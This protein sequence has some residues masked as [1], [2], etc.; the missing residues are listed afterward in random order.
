MRTLQENPK[1]MGTSVD[2]RCR[3]ATTLK[4]LAMVPENRSSFMPQQDRLITLV[5]SHV[6]DNAVLTNL[7]ESRSALP[8]LT[9][10]R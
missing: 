9:G 3:T 4:H 6:L 1:M 7:L 10:G 8:L 5:M 2:V